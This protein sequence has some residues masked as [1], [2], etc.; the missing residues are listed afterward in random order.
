MKLIIPK[1]N[2]HLSIQK[3]MACNFLLKENFTWIVGWCIMYNI[4][5]F[6]KYNE[7]NNRKSI[8]R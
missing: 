6:V 2:A 4:S 3:N 7:W 5:I 1:D 8:K